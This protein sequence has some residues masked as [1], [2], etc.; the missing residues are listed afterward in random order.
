MRKAIR[1]VS[2]T[3]TLILLIIALVLNLTSKKVIDEIK[4][5]TWKAIIPESLRDK[6]ESTSNW[7]QDVMNNDTVKNFV[8]QYIDTDKIKETIEDVK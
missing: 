1:V 4:E 3:F 7:F 6:K 5:E 2:L 8:D